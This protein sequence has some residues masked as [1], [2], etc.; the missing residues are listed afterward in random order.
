MPGRCGSGVDAPRAF[1]T[2]LNEAVIPQHLQLHRHR[3]L[4]DT[5]RG[6]DHL[7]DGSGGLLVAGQHLQDPA[8]RRVAQDCERFHGQ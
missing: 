1:G 3:R 6:R 5:D 8:A 4:S 7:D 2:D